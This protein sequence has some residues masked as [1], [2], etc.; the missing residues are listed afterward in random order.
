MAEAVEKIGGGPILPLGVV[1]ERLG[2]PRSGER[3]YGGT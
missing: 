2:H 1:L 3:K